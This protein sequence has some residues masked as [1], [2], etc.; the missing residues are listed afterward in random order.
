MHKGHGNL[1][2]F[3]LL[4]LLTLHLLRNAIFTLHGRV[5]VSATSTVFMIVVKNLHYRKGTSLA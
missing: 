1:I 3:V 5:H 4:E 2:K